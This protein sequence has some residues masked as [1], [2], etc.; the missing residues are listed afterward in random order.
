MSIEKLPVVLSLLANIDSKG[1][2]PRSEWYSKDFLGHLSKLVST[3]T[4][5]ILE[6]ASQENKQRET[7]RLNLS[8]ALFVKDLFNVMD[9]KYVYS[10]VHFFCHDF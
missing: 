10:L 2:K 3:V 9:W 4:E 1:S 6:L 7:K 8:L 5:I